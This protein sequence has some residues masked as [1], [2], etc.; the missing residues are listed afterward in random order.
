MQLRYLKYI[1]NFLSNLLK[2]G[3]FIATG[4]TNDADSFLEYWTVGVIMKNKDGKIN[5]RRMIEKL[6][7]KVQKENKII[8]RQKYLKPFNNN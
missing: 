8:L 7:K 2:T 6:N 5:K 4:A 1:H 3:T